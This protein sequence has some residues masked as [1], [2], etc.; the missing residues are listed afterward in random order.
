MPYYITKEEYE[1]LVYLHQI[2]NSPAR[3]FLTLH[4]SSEQALKSCQDYYKELGKKYGFDGTKVTNVIK[5]ENVYQYEV[6]I[7]ALH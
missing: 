4:E 2:L 3:Q 6:I 7:N 1:K 5:T